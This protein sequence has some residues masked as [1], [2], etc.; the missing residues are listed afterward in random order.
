MLTV[1]FITLLFG[2]ELAALI[3]MSVVLAYEKVFKDEEIHA[4]GERISGK[5]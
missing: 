5:F 2:L 1:L 3:I 4:P